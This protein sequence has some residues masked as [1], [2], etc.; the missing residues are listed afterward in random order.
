[1]QQART[2]RSLI[3]PLGQDSYVTLDMFSEAIAWKKYYL[4]VMKENTRAKG[5]LQMKLMDEVKE[6]TGCRSIF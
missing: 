2:P 1:M 4:H 6:V 3:I 5:R